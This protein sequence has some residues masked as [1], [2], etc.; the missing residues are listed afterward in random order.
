MTKEFVSYLASHHVYFG[1]TPFDIGGSRL[2]K[3]NE[4]D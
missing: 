4:Q 3:V 2:V 1:R